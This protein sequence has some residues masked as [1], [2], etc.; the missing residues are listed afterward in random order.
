M[1]WYRTEGS[2]QKYDE[3]FDQWLPRTQRQ[4]EHPWPYKI[5]MAKKTKGYVLDAGCG[6]GCLARFIKN[7]LFL[8]FSSVAL[9]KRWVGGS[10]PRARSNVEQLPFR[11][12]VFDSI[13]AVEVMEHLDDPKRFIAEV[14][15]VLKKGG[16]F[17]FASP[18]NDPSETHKWKEISNAVIDDWLKP[19]FPKYTFAVPPE[20]KERFMIY[21]YK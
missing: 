7:G 3:H 17:T 12:E 6:F 8:D 18:W 11:N 20:R 9:K 2:P 14:Y 21:A 1:S 4:A 16:F 10:R 15:R 5:I 19:F 13:L